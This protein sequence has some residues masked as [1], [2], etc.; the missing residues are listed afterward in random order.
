MYI[1]VYRSK[2]G[3]DRLEC[4]IVSGGTVGHSFI[5]KLSSKLVEKHNDLMLRGDWYIEIAGAQIQETNIHGYGVIGTN[6]IIPQASKI[7]TIPAPVKA[8]G[9]RGLLTTGQRSMM[10]VRVSVSDSTP[11]YTASELEPWYFD[12]DSFSV[13]R[14]YNLCSSGQQIFTPWSTPV[15]DVFV[16][17]DV[18][19]FAQTTLVNA[20]ISAVQ[21]ALGGTSFPMQHIAF[22]LPPGMPNFVAVG[23]VGG[24]R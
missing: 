10:V 6:L 2:G 12:P 1:E 5:I 11:T 9:R 17:G 16:S 23:Q 8:E 21:T 20:A 24:W 22:I 18:A 13:T 3:K 7:K 14:Q 15:M 4:E 19:S